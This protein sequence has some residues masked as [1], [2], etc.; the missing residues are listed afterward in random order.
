MSEDLRA[1]YYCNERAKNLAHVL[2]GEYEY[3]FV[4]N[5]TLYGYRNDNHIL[6]LTLDE[7]RLS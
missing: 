5:D 3:F 7:T 6:L 4:Q 2:V 1:Y